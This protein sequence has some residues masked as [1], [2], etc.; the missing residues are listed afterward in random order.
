MKFPIDVGKRTNSR[1]R[2]KKNIFHL[3]KSDFFFGFFAAF[4]SDNI[5]VVFSPNFLVEF[6]SHICVRY[7]YLLA[8]NGKKYVLSILC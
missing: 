2:G 8:K 3:N 7:F 5:F 6:L 1:T 4:S